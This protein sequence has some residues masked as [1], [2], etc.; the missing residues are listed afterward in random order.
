MSTSRASALNRGSLIS[1][2][3]IP[4]MTTT[5]PERV[6]YRKYNFKELVL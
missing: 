2:A 5:P 3:P 1:G 4:T 6:A